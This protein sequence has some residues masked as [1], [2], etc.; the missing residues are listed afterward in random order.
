MNNKI[1]IVYLVLLSCLLV[2]N[3]I[4]LVEDLQSKDPK[5]AQQPTIAELE[6]TRGVNRAL[7][8]FALLSQLQTRE[9]AQK[10]RQV[11]LIVYNWLGV[12]PSDFWTPRAPVEQKTAPSVKQMLWPWGRTFVTQPTNAPTNGVL[13]QIIEEGTNKWI[14]AYRWVEVR[15]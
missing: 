8:T 5:P 3:G 14:W 7:E 6:F 11:A 13:G 10:M 12:P 9:E 2:I 15:P 4:L 1:N